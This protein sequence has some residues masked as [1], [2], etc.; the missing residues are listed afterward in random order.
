MNIATRRKRRSKK[1]DRANMELQ[2]LNTGSRGWYSN[3]TVMKISF[4]YIEVYRSILA[5]F[6]KLN[7]FKV[8]NIYYIPYILILHIFKI[9]I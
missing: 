9:Y 6:L 7:V 3:P 8:K 5:P 2:M 4:V 1:S